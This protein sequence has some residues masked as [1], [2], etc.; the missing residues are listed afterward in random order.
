[1]GADSGRI[2]MVIAGGG[3]G[4]HLYP[5]LA[6]AE[7]V[8]ERR[9]D[10]RLLFAGLDNERERSEAER[11]GLAFLGLPLLGLRRKWSLRNVLAVW[12]FAAGVATCLRELGKSPAGV[13]FGVG[14]YVSAPAM[15][16]GKLLRWRVALHE[17]NTVPGLV[18]RLI[19]PRC[20]RVFL[21]FGSARDRLRAKSA[22]EA[23]YPVRKELLEAA[24]NAPPGAD[25]G[26]PMILLTG[27]SQGARSM[28]EAASGALALLAARGVRFKALVQTGERNHEW[29]R[30]LPWPPEAELVPFIRAMGKA[31]A[32]ASV[33]IARAGAGT[34]TEI[35]LF[36]RPAVL[37]PYPFA[38]G[39]HQEA[40]ADEWADAGAAV[41][42]RNRDLT[43][44]ALCGA[45][46]DLLPDGARREAMG[47]RAASMV[48]G[49][50]AATM[51]NELIRMLE[52]RR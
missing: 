19:A 4:G 1:M 30:G 22:S 34:L 33:V 48:R 3:T 20:D 40:N 11:R 42:I 2:H 43:P 6:V 16:A 44:E 9:P 15:L 45:L 8:L 31:Y 35:G 47:Q 25:A 32:A 38:A 13:V 27:G 46:Q 24:K 51:A 12:R 18:N 23:G 52:E 41:K 10:W 37:V 21:T 36:K 49:D 17:Q 14:G 5:A 28:V 26:T 29:A 7:A 39:N 50:A